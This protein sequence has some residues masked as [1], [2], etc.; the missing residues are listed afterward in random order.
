LE[1]FKPVSS[2]FCN[3]FHGFFISLIRYGVTNI[4][5]VDVTSENSHKSPKASSLLIA[6]VHKT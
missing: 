4:F 1:N 5:V 3:R 2:F 6:I